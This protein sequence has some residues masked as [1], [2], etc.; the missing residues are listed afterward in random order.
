MTTLEDTNAIDEKK[1][2]DVSPTNYK[3]FISNYITSIIFTIGVSVIL[4]GS[5]GLYTTKVAQSN[6]LPDNI[7]LAPY[8]DIIRN[9]QETPI[10]MNI[11]RDISWNLKVH[12]IV[13]QKAYFNEAQFLDNFKNT[14]TGNVLGSLKSK[15]NPSSGFF[16]NGGLYFS[17]IYDSMMSKN[18]GFINSLFLYLSYLPETAIML[19]YGFFGMF[20]WVGLY[21]FNFFT[22]IMYHISYILQFFRTSLPNDATKWEASSDVSLVGFNKIGKWCLFFMLWWWVALISIFITP[23]ITSLLTLISP[24]QTNYKLDRDSKKYLGIFDFIK[25]TIVYK[26]SFIVILSTVSLLYNATKYLGV[27]S[28]IGV[29]VAIMIAYFMGLYSQHIPDVNNITEFSQKLANPDSMQ[30]KVSNKLSGGAIKQ[31]HKHKL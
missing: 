7:N 22:S 24:L 30:A 19:L 9:V 5:L 20:I 29:I 27:Q 13:S 6:I 10:D 11:V 2:P 18:F 8:T 15:S 12:N 25:D 3:S 26:K 31:K 14:L 16:S 28:L 4:I 21:I 1:E 17:S 23:L